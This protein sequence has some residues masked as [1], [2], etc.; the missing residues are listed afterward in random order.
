MLLFRTNF[1]NEVLHLAAEPEVT[2]LI[3]LMQYAAIFH[4]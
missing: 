4:G 2:E 1:A 3:H